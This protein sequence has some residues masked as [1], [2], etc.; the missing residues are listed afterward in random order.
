MDDYTGDYAPQDI[1][2]SKGMSVLCYLGFLFIIPLLAGKNTPYVKFHIRQGFNLFLL[3]VLLNLVKWV[4]NLLFDNFLFMSLMVGL[5][6]IFAI[7]N[8]LC[9]TF[10]VMGVLGV[11]NGRARE[12]PIIGKI[13]II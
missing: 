4:A 13:H 6:F 1:Q 8:I 9:I 3:E 2:A 5:N 7:L 12:L 10:A 11:V